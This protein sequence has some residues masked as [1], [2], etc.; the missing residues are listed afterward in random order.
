MKE[1]EYMA[2]DN[3]SVIPFIVKVINDIYTKITE[4]GKSMEE[5][6]QKF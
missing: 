1:S 4:I 5:L 2:D 6:N 3:E